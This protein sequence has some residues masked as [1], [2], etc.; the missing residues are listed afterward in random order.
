MI[1]NSKKKLQLQQLL[2]AEKTTQNMISSLQPLQQRQPL[3]M[4]TTPIRQIPEAEKTTIAP[5]TQNDKL[6]P[7][8]PAKTTTPSEDHTKKTNSIHSN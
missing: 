6:T 1:Y 5:S 4:K 7:A 2:E 8:T 3:Q